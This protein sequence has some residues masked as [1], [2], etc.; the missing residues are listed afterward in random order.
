MTKHTYSFLMLILPLV[1]CCNKPASDNK[2]IIYTEM[3]NV[4]PIDSTIKRDITFSV[5]TITKVTSEFEKFDIE[6]FRENTED[7]YYHKRMDNGIDIE[8][9]GR[10]EELT[11]QETHPDSYFSIFKIFDSRGYIKEKGLI[12]AKSISGSNMGV[13]YYFDESGKLI[14]EINYDKPFT[15]TFNDVLEFCKKEGIP[16]SKGIDYPTRKTINSNNEPIEITY[17]T[18]MDRGDNDYM[19]AKCWWLIDYFST[20]GYKR[21]VIYLDGQTGKVLSRKSGVITP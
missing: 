15:F 10:F 8:I 1:V 18:Q 11:Y 14:N 4:I 2:T 20:N 16:V 7:N 13:W 21:T 3:K 19:G 17:V 12:I 6:T 9:S 5:M